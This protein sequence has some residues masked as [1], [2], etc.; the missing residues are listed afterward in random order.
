[1]SRLKS[2][3]R[4]LVAG[5]AIFL[6]ILCWIVFGQTRRFEFVNFDDHLYVYDNAIV[7]HG[8]SW[9]GL[10]W[11]LTEAHGGNWHPLTTLSHML[12]C[13]LFGLNAGAQHLVNLFFH[14]IGAVLL[15][16]VLRA[17]TDA[18]WRSAMVA[19]LFAIHPQHV[20]S[21]AWISE[22]KDVLSGFFFMLALASYVRYARQPSRRRYLILLL[23]SAGGLLAKPMLVTLP[24]VLLLLDYWPLH[25]FE[26]VR[27]AS[28]MRRLFL[29]KVPILIFAV[30][31]SVITYVIQVTH[32]SLNDS[33]ALAWRAGNAVSSYVLYLQQMIWPADLS[34][35]YPHPENHLSLWKIA[36]SFFILIL[37]SALVFLRRRSNPYLLVGWFWY[38]GM[39]LPVIG[40]VQVGAQG[41]ADRYTYLPGIG[42]YIALV[43]LFAEATIRLPY[44][45]QLS[46]IGAACILIACAVVARKQT[47]I[48]RDSE[49]L[50]NRAL[51]VTKDNHLAH[52]G[53]GMLEEKQGRLDEALSRYRTAAEIR[54]R[55]SSRTHDFFLASYDTNIAGVLR[56][57][58]QPDEAIRY[59]RAALDFQPN[60]GPAYRI[61]AD[62]LVDEG[63]TAEAIP[64]FRQAAETYPADAQFQLSMAQALL[65]EGEEEEAVTH[66]ER[67]L[68]F[69]HDSLPALN[70]LAW[71]YATSSK[72]DLRHGERAVLVA[73]R[74]VQLTA[75]KEPFYLHKL[76]AA[77]AEEGDFAKA[78]ATADF[79][80]KLALDQSNAGLA[81]ELQRNIDIYRTN[82]PLRD[83]RRPR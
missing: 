64:L 30:T 31:I 13:Q 57:Q 26:S 66:F 75:Q 60:Y 53:L 28:Q 18:I 4:A 25:R 7:R 76:A 3:R 45:R 20:E 34:P 69:D 58:G 67:A 16:L 38:V 73:E 54:T 5:I 35:L 36:G 32:G 83:R 49:T 79:A 71:I 52:N 80:K 15:F 65:R 42:I 81:D 29:E 8:L 33:L 19:A 59:C 77:Y 24:F 43:W 14:S 50:W 51:A 46:A 23:A 1:M 74:A 21:V 55:L 22:R 48:W 82:S 39:L 61:W 72:A 9:P 78:L 11:A 27:D 47:Q 12:D 68:V 63:Q 37:I 41:W 44:R 70:N 10:G 2:P 6:I 56:R 40:L 62:A 17:M